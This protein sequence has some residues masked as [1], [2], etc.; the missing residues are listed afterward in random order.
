FHDAAF[1]TRGKPQSATLVHKTNRNGVEC[2]E[3]EVHVT[4]EWLTRER[5]PENYL[6]LDRGIYNLAAY[7]IVSENGTELA[8][9]RISG[10]ELRQVQGQE[11]KRIA[12]SQ[13]RGKPVRGIAKR[14]AWADE[15]IH[16][17][18]NQIVALAVE[19]N[20]RVVV[21]DLSALSAIR[22]RTRIKGTRRS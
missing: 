3:F 7:A 6:G 20:A 22:R 21:E 18:A 13:H 8:K 10:R 19:Q 11:E 5:R 4:F 9:G 2:D 12:S 1:I 17:T 16:V 14:R 15:A